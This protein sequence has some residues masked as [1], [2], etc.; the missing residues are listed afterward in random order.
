MR[1]HG[2]AVTAQRG[3]ALELRRGEL[4][5]LV[6]GR[7]VRG[8]FGLH[9]TAHG[10][11]HGTVVFAQQHDESLGKVKRWLADCNRLPSIWRSVQPLN[12]NAIAGRREATRIGP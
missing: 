6:P 8:Y 7:S 12:G 9:I 2:H 3:Q 4:V 1:G 5:R 10:V 11:L